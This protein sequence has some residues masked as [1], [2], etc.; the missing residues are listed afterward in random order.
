MNMFCIFS[1]PGF[2]FLPIHYLWVSEGVS[3]QLHL[4]P[5]PSDYH[6]GVLRTGQLSE[7]SQPIG[8]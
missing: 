7:V 3:M 2:S 4:C 5:S 8:T 6:K 1:V